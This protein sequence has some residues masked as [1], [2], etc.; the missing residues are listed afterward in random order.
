MVG[1][2]PGTTRSNEIVLIVAHLDNMPS[3]PIAP[4]A[5][6][7]GSGVAGVLLS[8][9]IFRQFQFE[10]TLQFLLVSGEE[11]GLLGSDAYAATA[12]AASNNIVAVLTLD[13]IAW[14]NNQDGHLDLYTRSTNNPGYSSDFVIA[15]TFTNVV[16]HY[17]LVPPLVPQIFADSS[18]WYSDHSSFWNNGYAAILAIEDNIQDFNPFYHSTNDTLQHFNMPYFASFVRAALGTVAHLAQ[19]VTRAPLDIVEVASTAAEPGNGIGAGTFYAR[20]EALATEAGAD[21]LDQTWAEAPANTNAAWL[22]IATQ[23]YGTALRRD[24]RP[25]ASETLFAGTLSAVSTG[26][27]P[28]TCT[29]RLRFDFLTP[30]QADRLYF[31]RIHIP[32]SYTATANDYHC[33]TNLRSV[34]DSGGYLDLPVLVNASN[35]V[36]YGTCEI[37]SRFLDTGASNCTLQLAGMAETQVVFSTSVQLGAQIEDQ[38]EVNTNL[39]QTNGWQHLTAVIY[40]HSPADDA[41]ESGWTTVMQGVDSASLTNSPSFFFRLKRLWQEY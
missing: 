6:D 36:P 30:P 10:R 5:D 29:N 19:P 15:S 28:L 18:V 26:T 40:A 7:N 16:A 17:P 31:A 21:L 34:V 35:D 37:A 39:L 4:G 33:V 8:A 25:L 13:M 22:K 2:L 24:A 32:G 12:L 38:I 41:F 23:P 9:E 27:P 11:Q 20:H 3:G 1:T 14:D